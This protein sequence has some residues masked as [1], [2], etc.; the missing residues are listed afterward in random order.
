MIDV[1]IDKPS[2]FN[3]YLLLVVPRAFCLYQEKYLPNF[4]DVR[5][6]VELNIVSIMLLYLQNII[7][8]PIYFSQS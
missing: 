6:L 3:I 5:V 8:Q 4:L 1:M 2:P 7:I